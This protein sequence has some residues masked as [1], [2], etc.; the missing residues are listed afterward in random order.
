[1]IKANENLAIMRGFRMFFDIVI[2][3]Y[4]VPEFS[5]LPKNVADC[6]CA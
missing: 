1:M 2:V 6:D 3:I 5:S 4:Q